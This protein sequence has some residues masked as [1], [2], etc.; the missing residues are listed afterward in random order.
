MVDSEKIIKTGAIAIQINTGA[1]VIWMMLWW[2][3][4]LRTFQ[5]KIVI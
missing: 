5:Q 1:L 2:D 4:P 3:A